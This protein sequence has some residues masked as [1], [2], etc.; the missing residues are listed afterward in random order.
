MERW[1]EREKKEMGR[2]KIKCLR[3]R[4]HRSRL[5]NRREKRWRRWERRI[6]GGG[7]SLGAEEGDG[8]G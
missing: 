2:R 3:R 7:W 8:R 1:M 5:K 6:E 4:K